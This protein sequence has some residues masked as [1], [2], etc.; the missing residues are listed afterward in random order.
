MSS[1]ANRENILFEMIASAGIVT[2]LLIGSD[3]R[4]LACICDLGVTRILLSPQGVV[5][6]PVGDDARARTDPWTRGLALT[7]TLRL[8]YP[9]S[10]QTQ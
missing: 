3:Q 6:R 2:C 10:I 7:A 5:K 9:W 8:A 1:S 4:N